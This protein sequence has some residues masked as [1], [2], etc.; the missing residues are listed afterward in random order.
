MNFNNKDVDILTNLLSTTDQNGLKIVR[1]IQMYLLNNQDQVSHKMQSNIPHSQIDKSGFKPIGTWHPV[2]VNDE[3]VFLRKE[4]SDSIFWESSRLQI[5]Q[6]KAP[7]T[8]RVCVIGES[9]AAG[10]FFT[11]YYSPA[12][13]LSNHLQQH[14]N[15]KW[16]VIDLTRSCMNAG[17]LIATCESCLQLG[18][19]FIIIIAGN[20]WFSDI[21]FEHDGPFSKRRVYSE[22]LKDIGPVGISSAFKK[23]MVTHAEHIMQKLDKIAKDSTADFVFVLPASNFGHWER[24][25]PIYWLGNERTAEWYELYRKASKALE[26]SHYENALQIGFEMLALDG[27]VAPTSNRIIAN[28]LIGLGRSDEAYPYCV[29]ESDYAVM[30]DQL[31]AFPGMPSFVREHCKEMGKK[32]SITILDLET[33]FI[34]HLNSKVLDKSLFV[35]Y[36]HMTPEGFHIA[37]APAANFLINH[38]RFKKGSVDQLAINWKILAKDFKAFEIDKFQLAISYFYIALYNI[39]LNEPVVN[40]PSLEAAVELFEKSVSYSEKILDVMEL[41]VQARSCY[42]G[43]GF[44]LSKAGQRLFE[45]CNSP[46]DFP[47]AQAAPGVDALTIEAI[48]TLLERKGRRGSILMASYQQHYLQLL[49]YGADLTEPMYIERINSVIRLAIDSE[50][51]TYRKVPYFKSWWPCSYFSLVA[52]L[53]DDLELKITCRIPSTETNIINISLNNNFVGCI[54]PTN[55]WSQYRFVIS[56]KSLFKG[57]NR[58]SIEWPI[59]NQ[60]EHQQILDLSNRYSMGLKVDMFPVFGEIFSLIVRRIN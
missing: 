51:S 44:S 43:A 19:D 58:L 2:E 47:V 21:I 26:D 23:N 3:I 40:S 15:D 60:N 59:L 32:I 28:S 5:K 55:K 50:L 14:S 41:Y 7:S 9:A 45:L 39:H 6:K 31:T 17:G 56:K 22:I 4:Q 34:D 35:D 30:Y 29:A 24:R 27:G 12:I 38:L 54:L 48:C 53:E 46:L 37:M 25:C 16:E 8:K 57:F 33:I 10:M 13:A 42:Y 18:P 20:N 1:L 36:C 49:D 52:D 11:P